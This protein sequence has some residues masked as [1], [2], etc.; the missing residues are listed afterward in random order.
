MGKVIE[1]LDVA[2]STLLAAEFLNISS[3]LIVVETGPV[4]FGGVAMS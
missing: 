1:T 2:F 4:F 3:I